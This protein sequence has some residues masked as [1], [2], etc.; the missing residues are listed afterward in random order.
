MQIERHNIRRKRR[1]VVIS[2]LI[3]IILL[4]IMGSVI[5]KKW[6]NE[7]VENQEASSN[8]I[9]NNAEQNEISQ[10]NKLIEDNIE[11]K[12]ENKVE[13]EIINDVDI[14]NQTGANEEEPTKEPEKTNNKV[15]FDE[16]VAFIGNS[17][18]QGFIMY[19]GL[20]KVQ[21]YTYI[22][23]MVDTAMTKEFVKTGN[24]EKITLLQ[25][26]KNKDIK[27]VYIMLGI[28]ELGWSYPSVFKLKYEELIDEIRK[29]KSDCNIYVQSIIPVTKSKDQSDKIYNNTNVSK[30]NK[31]IKEVANEKN[32]KYLDVQSVLVNSEGYLPEDASTDG[33]HI[34]KRYCEKWLNYL[35]N[36]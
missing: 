8:E 28:N 29:V 27:K 30:F 10:Q 2:S 9:I 18:T 25:D 1:N 20:T 14:S 5:G 12:V 22:G 21:D 33:I 16:T 31:L 6:A 3:P 4:F 23:L 15:K 19:N 13:N 24:G 35:K 32:V 36:I 11:N 26:M 7:N 34:G 17:R